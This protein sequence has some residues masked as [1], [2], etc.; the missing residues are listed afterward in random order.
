MKSSLFRNTI[1]TTLLAAAMACAMPLS[2]AAQERGGN[3][4]DG[5]DARYSRSDDR[6]FRDR[7]D[8]YRQQRDRD[9]R[10]RDDN[11]RR[12]DDWHRSYS[13][14]YRGDENPGFRAFVVIR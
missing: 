2:A 4:R 6:R 8:F 3:G 5:N 10:D 13:H 12:G 14:N 7:D 11:W 1:V 9:R